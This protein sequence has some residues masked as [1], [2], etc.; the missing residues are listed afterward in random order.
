MADSDSKPES[1]ARLWSRATKWGERQVSD[2]RN[3]DDVPAESE[4]SELFSRAAARLGALR[5]RLSLAPDEALRR[6]DLL[7][8][9]G[10]PTEQSAMLLD[11]TLGWGPAV[12]AALLQRSKEIAPA[13]PEEGMRRAHL[14]LQVIWRFYLDPGHGYGSSSLLQDLRARAASYNGN[15]LR[16]LSRYPEAEEQF[17]RALKTVAQ[18]SGDPLAEAEIRHL[19]GSLLRDRRHFPEARRALRRAAHLYVQAGQEHEVGKVLFNQALNEREAGDPS[20]A[21]RLQRKALGYLD[22]SFEPHLVAAGYTNLALF[23][24]EA[25]QAEAARELLEE[26]PLSPGA[27]HTHGEHRT[28][29]EGLVAT[30]LG[31]R[32]RAAELI[33]RA[34][35]AFAEL[36]D[37]HRF[38]TCTVDLAAVYA[39]QG[40]LAAVRHLVAQSLRI[41]QTLDV[42]RDAMAAFLLFQQAAATEVLSVATL[43]R[44]RP[45]LEDRRLWRAYRK[46]S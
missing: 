17:Q 28:W 33:D 32:E 40:D 12:S 26:H 4:Y 39:E 21:S 25:G 37:G 6:A 23:M 1:F 16:L 30:H 5:N 45:G 20:K 43:R 9:A 22:A 11:P 27:L 31:E 19:H 35:R 2:S 44:I 18:G 29:I 8:A 42:P 24:A 15:A 46:P 36:G 10:S 34:R 7:A 38:A 13:Q 41:L 14:A 3:L